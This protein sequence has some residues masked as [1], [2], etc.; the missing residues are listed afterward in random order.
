[1][2]EC[3]LSFF[4]FFRK[5]FI[6]ILFTWNMIYFVLGKK[7]SKKAT[8]VLFLTVVSIKTELPLSGE[9]FITIERKL[10]KK[11]TRRELVRTVPADYCILFGTLF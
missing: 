6:D 9:G 2:D 7:Y 11:N 10:R 4:S 3:S 5:I 1:M 8:R